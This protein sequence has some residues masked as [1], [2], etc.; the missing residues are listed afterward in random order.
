MSV[1]ILLITHDDIG[2]SLIDT[3]QQTFKVLPLKIRALSVHQSDDPL[4]LGYH[5]EILYN[6]LEEGDGVLVLTDL[7]A[8]TPCNIACSL[9]K[10]YRVR[11][12]SGVNLPMLVK[13]MNYA[14]CDLN[15]LAELAL[16]GGC[17]GILD[18]AQLVKE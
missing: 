3:L 15:K 5:A 4:I 6:G 7:F 8:A 10:H 1:G 2:T 16:A 13:L 18:V 17:Q 9:L 14:K 12:V 11:L